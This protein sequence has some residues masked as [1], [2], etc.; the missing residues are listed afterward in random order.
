MASEA[1]FGDERCSQDRTMLFA[2]LRQATNVTAIGPNYASLASH[3]LRRR[4]EG[5]GHTAT[6]ELSPRNAITE[7]CG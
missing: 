7:H 1:I 2:Q 4:E 6:T 5:S 3:T